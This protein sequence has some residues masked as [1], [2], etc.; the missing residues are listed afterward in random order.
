MGFTLSASDREKLQ[1]VIKDVNALT[2][3]KE[4]GRSFN[5]FNREYTYVKLTE[6][7][8]D[9]GIPTLFWYASEVGFD[10]AGA[11]V[12]KTNGK[13]WSVSTNPLLVEGDVGAVDDVVRVEPSALSDGSLIWLA[14]KPAS[15]GGDTKVRLK[16]KAT[17]TSLVGVI[18]LCDIIDNAGVVLTVGVNVRQRKFASAKFYINEIIYAD[19]EGSDYIADAYLAGIGVG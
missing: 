2:L 8:L 12:V 1:K 7:V 10:T 9:G 5:Q 3:S 13:V 16:V 18:F 19:A 4:Q 15:G 14:I 11:P 17:A 6:N